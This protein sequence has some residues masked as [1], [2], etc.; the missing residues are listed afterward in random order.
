MKIVA[1][2]GSS[3]GAN[4]NTNVMVSTFLKGAQE[5]GADTVHVFLAEKDI[6]HCKGCHTCWKRG[7]GQCVTNDDMG[8]VLGVL[9]GADVIILASPVYFENIS[10]MLKVFMDRMTMIGG[11]PSTKEENEE[12]QPLVPAKGQVANEANS[13][14]LMMFSSCGYDDR[15]EFE[16]TSLWIKRVAQKMHMALIGEI[17]RTQGKF[18]GD[19]PE[20]LRSAISNYLK[21]LEK[22][23]KEIAIDKKFSRETEELLQ[24]S[25]LVFNH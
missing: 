24:I 25:H 15:S 8:E 10:G 1:I 5:A 16:V 21:L 6:K 23:G 22:A 18:L 11:P 17:Y 2:N 20:E 13:P 19:P 4:S 9:G 12:S 3:K 14:K 7:P